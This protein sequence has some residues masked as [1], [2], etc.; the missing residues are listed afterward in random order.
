VYRIDTVAGH[1][2][3]VNAE[4][5]TKIVRSVDTGV[6]IDVEYPRYGSTLHLTLSQGGD[7]ASTMKNR[8][9]RMELNVGD[10]PTTVTELRHAAIEG[11]VVEAPSARVTPLQLLATDNRTFVLSGALEPSDSVVVMSDVEAAAPIVEAL[12][13]DMIKMVEGL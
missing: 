7:V 9:E 2:I 1:F 6:W 10:S 5:V 12:R 8:M 3:T 11:M 4:A 13:R